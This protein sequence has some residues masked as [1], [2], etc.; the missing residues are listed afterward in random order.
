MIL[1]YQYCMRVHALPAYGWLVFAASLP[2]RTGAAQAHASHGQCEAGMIVGRV[3]DH[4]TERPVAKATVVS[5]G[6]STNTDSAGLF[7]LRHVPPGA[8]E[9]N[10]TAPHY[11]VR[12]VPVTICGPDTLRVFVR[13]AAHAT[14]LEQVVVTATERPRDAGGTSGSRIGREAIEHVQASSLADVLQLLP[15]QTAVNPTLAGVRQS[16]LRQA[17]TATTRDPGPGEEAERANAL[18]TALV[19]DGVPQSNNANLQGTL[20]ILNSGPNALPAFATSAN[21]G[22][23]L[24]QITADNIERVDVIRG[25]PSA[26]FGD[27]TTGAILVTTRAGARAPELRVRANPQTLELSSL[28]GWTL[29][30]RDGLSVDANFTRSQDDPRTVV[31]RFSRATIQTAWTRDRG[32][33]STT[34]RMRAYGVLDASRQDPDDRRYQR[35]ASSR[36][37]GVRVDAR[38]RAGRPAGWQTELTASGAFARQRS[39]YQELVTRDIFPV[40]AARRDTLAPG[41]YGRSEYLTQ[42][43]VDGAPQNSYVRLE[44]TRRWRRAGRSYEPVVGLEW[45]T[46]A[47]RGDGRR[48]DPLAPPRQNYGVGDRPDDFARVRALQQFAAY[49][50]HTWRAVAWG[51]GLELRT[52]ARL[53]LFD[54]TWNGGRHGTVFAPRLAGSVLLTP[55][56]TTTLAYGT[57][58]KS[59]TLAQLYPSPRY[60][61]LTSFNYYPTNPAERLV[62][63]TTRVVQPS[64]GTVRAVT[65][66]KR[67]VSLEWRPGRVVLNATVFSEDTRGIYGTSRVPLGMLVPQYRAQSF[68]PGL[69][70]VLEPVPFRVDSFVALYDTPRNSRT[71]DTRGAEW[72]LELPELRRVRVQFSVTGAWYR[73]RAADEDVD[74]PVD[75]FLGGTTPP[76]R[77]GVYASGRGSEADRG[78]TSVRLVHRQPAAGLAA[79][80]LWQTTWWD[81]DRP[82]GR[83]DGRPLGF[84]DRTGRITWLAANDASSP[85][86]EGLVRSVT[87]MAARWERRPPLHLIN[88]RV[89]KA[90][91]ARTQLAVFANNALADRP[92]YQRAR[93]LGFERRNPPLFFGIELLAMLP[94]LTSPQS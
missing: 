32:P 56:L 22:V 82:I 40:S 5:A 76:A 87:P 41:V 72:T 79:S 81:D 29:G 38:L 13:L 44:S 31:G 70:P 90:L 39:T 7:D 18:G 34:L 52:G 36:D 74:I 92:L 6:Q 64:A 49:G 62:L 73:S 46:D 83:L 21:R 48:F 16:L 15:G 12:I 59:P 19:L 93:A 85:S 69:P 67:E 30:G 25:V 53:D 8:V 75:Q 86:Y 10:V 14:Q 78:L 63:F 17:P 47:N 80:L 11:A 71:L 88:L 43:T 9:L 60:F 61:D 89:T 91:P 51:R 65:A 4:K 84:V 3:L 23:D 28:G 94:S 26:R 37:D 55:T 45:R 20:T 77:V 58:A 2:F 42:L 24:R 50:E 68:P 35:A 1:R 66:T 33:V 57:A 54:P 27:L